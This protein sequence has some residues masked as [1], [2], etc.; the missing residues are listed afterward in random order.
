MI[1]KLLCFIGLHDYYPKIYRFWYLEI[2][3][4]AK[5]KRKHCGKIKNNP[6]HTQIY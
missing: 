1:N 6:W 5:C 2:P 3:K 4:G